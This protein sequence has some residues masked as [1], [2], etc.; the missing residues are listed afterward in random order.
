M[1]T[2]LPGARIEGLKS[3][4]IGWQPKKDADDLYS[5][6]NNEVHVISKSE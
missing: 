5:S 4:A 3:C 2:T 6:F 1:L